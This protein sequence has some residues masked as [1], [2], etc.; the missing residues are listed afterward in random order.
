MVQAGFKLEFESNEVAQQMVAICKDVVKGTG[1][2]DKVE[3]YRESV[4]VKTDTLLRDGDFYEEQLEEG[5]ALIQQISFALAKKN[6]EIKF[7]GLCYYKTEDVSIRIHIKH[8]KDILSFGI[9]TVTKD[10][11]SLQRI[12]WGRGADGQFEKS[13]FGTKKERDR[14]PSC[15]QE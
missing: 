4:F 10:T 2:E 3:S 11:I 9:R 14:Y 6:P 15:P 5:Q 8:E 1:W 12:L 7:S 13:A